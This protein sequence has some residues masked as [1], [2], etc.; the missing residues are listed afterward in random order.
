MASVV[1]KTLLT[2]GGKGV[3]MGRLCTCETG[4]RQSLDAGHGSTAGA[5]PRVHNAARIGQNPCMISVP[6]MIVS[7]ALLADE[8][9]RMGG[10]ETPRES[11]RAQDSPV[12]PIG[13]LERALQRAG[14]NRH[15]LEDALAVAAGWDQGRA[16]EDLTWLIERMPVQDLKDL[17]SEFL[18]ENLEYAQRAWKESPWSQMVSRD[19][20]RRHILPY[21]SINERRDRW[22]AD[23]YDRFQGWVESAKNPTEAAT[24]LNRR[25][26]DELQVHYSTQRP[27]ADQSPYESIQAGMASCTGLSVILVDACRAVGVPARFVGTPLWTDGSGNHSWVEVWDHGWHYT[28]A[29]EPTGNELNKAWF[30]ERASTAVIGHKRHGI[31][32][33]SFEPTDLEF[34]LVWRPEA[35]RVF[36]EEVTQRY[37]RPLLTQPRGSL[38]VRFRAR[39]GQLGQRLAGQ[40]TIRSSS[41]EVV[42][43]GQTRDDS[44]DANDHLTAFLEPQVHYTAQWRGASQE[45]DLEFEVSNDQELIELDVA[46]LPGQQD[47]GL[48]KEEA[49][50]LS[51]ELWDAF[52]ERELNVRKDEWESKVLT[53]AGQSMPFWYK[54]YGKAPLRGHSLWISMH[55]GGGTTQA[56]NDQQWENQKRLYTPEEGIY[57]APRAPT[58]TWNLWHQG[59]IDPLFARLIEN[60]ILFEGVDPE[61]VYLLGYS[62][63]GDGVYQLAPRMADRFAAASM[64]AGHPNE[65]VPDGL[66]N[67]PFSLHMGA[68]DA[69]Y[70]RNQHARRWRDELATLRRNDGGGYEHWVEVYPDKGHWMDREDGAA[71]P[72]MAKFRRRSRPERIVWVQDDVTHQRFY[73]LHVEHPVARSRVV[74]QQHGQA[75]HL[76]EVVGITEL[77]LRLDDSMV[78]LGETIQVLHKGDVLW[79]GKAQRSAGVLEETLKERGDPSGMYCAQVSITIP[80][81]SEQETEPSERPSEAA[82]E[83]DG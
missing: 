77:D 36:A 28:G 69:A 78:D 34:P 1:P 25:V 59:H 29:D 13:D 71:L 17:T 46:A 48:S 80:A 9:V 33:V 74:I 21:A 4:E 57:V 5:C 37:Q 44:S 2:W 61:R 60:M 58:N 51:K 22:R 41:G 12:K 18:L 14:D 68:E 82:G 67:L 43:D 35:D 62:A 64:M 72:W 31:F 50:S 53:T 63:G 45:L 73:W 70:D 75:F 19:T 83:A 66:R 24:L 27:K 26:F 40:L 65:T 30:S 54:R 47:A 23:F 7:L 39:Q 42:F 32:A 3:C 16:R 11:V 79:E 49:T 6:V 56:V 55:G 81:P 38:R 76:L 20:Y 8:G 52:E 15:E 10:P